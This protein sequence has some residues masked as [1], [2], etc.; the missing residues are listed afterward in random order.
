[1]SLSYTIAPSLKYRQISLRQLCSQYEGKR[2]TV[3]V[4]IVSQPP[5]SLAKKIL[6]LQ[7][8]ADEDTLPNMYELPG[9]NWEESDAT[10]FDTI[11]REAKEETGLTMSAVLGEFEEFEY[12]TKRGLAKQLNFLVEVQQCAVSDDVS[13][14][15]TPTLCPSEHQAY[16][17]AEATDSLE[18]LPMTQ[19]MKT[20]IRNAFKAIDL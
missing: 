15:P 10:I 6:L 7:R 13:G 14:E 12:T 17:W 9:G 3:G 8:A 11:A 18:E 16:L 5:A 20:I 1:M 4:A 19:G 2:I